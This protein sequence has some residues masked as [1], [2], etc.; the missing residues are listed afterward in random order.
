MLESS[1]EGYSFQIGSQPRRLGV[2]VRDSCSP[3]LFKVWSLKSEPQHHLGACKTCKIL[4][5]T[6]DPLNQNLHF[7]KTLKQCDAH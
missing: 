2:L 7:D 4:D 6:L 3:L 1:T 5:P